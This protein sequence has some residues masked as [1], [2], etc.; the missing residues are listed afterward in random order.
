MSS[1][2]IL[3]VDIEPLHDL[4]E[5]W[6]HE[7]I[8]NVASL[9]T[10]NV[11]KKSEEDENPVQL[12]NYTDVYYNDRITAEIDFMQ[13]TASE[14]EIE[15][16]SLEPGDVVITKDS[17]SPDDIGVPALIAE[18]IDDLVCGYHLTI[19]R[20]FE[21]VIIGRYLFYA[22]ASR[23]SAYQFYLAANGVTRF[24]LTY[25][26]TKNLRIGFPPL[27]DQ[28]R[29]ADFLDYKTAKI[30]ALIAKKRELIEKLKEQRIAVIT[31]AVTQGLDPTAP[32]RDSGVDWL[33]QVPKH[34]AV[35]RLRYCTELVTSGSRGWAKYFSDSGS[36][37]LRITNLNRESISLRLEDVE[38]VDPP[39]GAEGART[40][41]QP[42]DLL[43]SITADLGSVA[44]VPKTL[45][46]A[47]VS[48]H[49][50]LV[51][52]EANTVIPDWIA[53]SV[54]SHSGKSQLLT[55]GYG[56]TKIQLNLND[57][58]EIVFCHP[59]LE[60]EQRQILG[61]VIRKT[62]RIDRLIS[63]IHQAIKRLTEYRTA[64]ITAATTGK[65]DV[66]RIK[67]G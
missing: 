32:M 19:L 25:Q 62:D 7:R 27:S 26:G 1:N 58:K 61:D 60:D 44:V 15:R 57:I 20:P 23:L 28:E 34:W 10:S 67:L 30:D 33:G 49:L 29:I 53:L 17:E 8:H 5:R 56:G 55:A 45:E 54:F 42:G 65:I 66:R 22:L 40:L 51:R 21:S 12:C 38:R 63:T 11:N 6:R 3:T 14:A 47:Y 59:P 36:L 37:F 18:K 13:A 24:G 41:T 50:A 35:K 46:P 52:P 4:P 2:A 48:Q 16:F 43:I 64:L 31:Q 9:R 39:D